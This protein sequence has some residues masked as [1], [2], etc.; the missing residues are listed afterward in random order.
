M[1]IRMGA[2]LAAIC[3]PLTS[4]A[5]VQT[6]NV[7]AQCSN[8]FTMS[9][10]GGLQWLCAGDLLLSGFEGMGTI[11]SDVGINLRATGTLTLDNITLLAPEI[12]LDAGSLQIHATSVLSA[13]NINLTSRTIRR[14]TDAT[15]TPTPIVSGGGTVQLSNGGSIGL[16]GQDLNPLTPSVPE[17][18]TWGLALISLLAMGATY[19]RRQA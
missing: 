7:N 1:S 5:S 2:L 11:S 9:G 8:Q 14:P 3:L 15:G 6:N 19:R 12:K 10:G 4:M 13:G 16:S 17:P 18:A